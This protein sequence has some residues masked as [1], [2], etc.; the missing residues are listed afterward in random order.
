MILLF[1]IPGVAMVIGTFHQAQL[2][3]VEMG[4]H[5][6]LLPGLAWNHDLS[7]FGLPSS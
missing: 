7:D 3:S 2:F 1:Y 6:L 4:S 5:K